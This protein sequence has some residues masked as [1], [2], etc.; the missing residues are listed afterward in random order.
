MGEKAWTV[1]ETENFGLF[2]ILPL[3]RSLTFILK[4]MAVKSGYILIANPE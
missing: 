2:K 3:V 1:Q 4:A